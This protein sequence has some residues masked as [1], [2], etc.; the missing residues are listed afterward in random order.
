MSHQAERQTE[1]ATCSSSS[2]RR[3]DRIDDLI[4]NVQLGNHQSAVIPAITIVAETDEAGNNHA[5]RELLSYQDC[6]DQDVLWKALP[7]IE[8][9]AEFAP[10]LFAHA[11]LARMANNPDFSVRSS[12][13][14]ICMNLAQFAPSVVPVDLLMKLSASDED[15][16]VERP[17]N[18]ALKAIARSMPAV[19]QIFFERLHGEAPEQ[20]IHAAHNI[21]DIAKC[22][23]QILDVKKLS[24]EL[25]ILRVKTRK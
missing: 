25:S 12:A 13:A 20:R 9:C 14:S 23:P 15:W 2:F 18:A 10:Q 3:S 21:A 11:V 16:Y 7:T 22:E 1:E 4:K 17:A 5:L 19:L 24:R 8:A 6:E